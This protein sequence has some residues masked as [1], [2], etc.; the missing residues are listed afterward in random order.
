MKPRVIALRAAGTNCDRE[1]AFAFEQVGAKA[2]IVHINRLKD[3]GK[4]LNNYH[5]LVIPGGFT[6][7][8]DIASGKI[9]ANELKF[10]LAKEMR[11]FL[12]Q[13]KL[14]LGICNG[15]QVLVKAGLLP[16]IGKDQKEFEA[17]L[18][19][20]DSARFEARWVYLLKNEE[21]KCAWTKHVKYMSYL[22][23]AHAE[24]KFVPRDNRVLDYLRKNNQ[25]VFKYIDDKGAPNKY[26][27]NPNGS[28]D[29]I[30][31][32]CDTTG[33]ILGMMPHPERYITNTQ[34][35]HWTRRDLIPEGDGLA[36]FRS[37]VESIVRNTK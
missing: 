16:D 33:R 19:L 14:I 4:I 37:G 31:G 36:L 13:K 32:I 10:T 2:D 3:D 30:A 22:P 8:D 26:P 34:H 25:I 23:V 29:D 21:S 18:N 24:G 11:K 6:Y 28:V 12:S 5:I 20:N 27:W 1:T 7:G 17:T 35:P 9:L 15:F